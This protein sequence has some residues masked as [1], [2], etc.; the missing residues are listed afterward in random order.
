MFLYLEMD[1]KF[2][3]NFP[4]KT[5]NFL[6]WLDS[7]SILVLYK[8]LSLNKTLFVAVSNDCDN[9]NGDVNRDY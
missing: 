4:P 5:F 8:M 7:N 9:F 6:F 3:E 1:F 2:L